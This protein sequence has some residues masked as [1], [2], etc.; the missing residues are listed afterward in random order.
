MNG[1]ASR[2]ESQSSKTFCPALLVTGLVLFATCGRADPVPVEL[3][4]VDGKW[5]L[6]R[7]GQPYLIRGAGG[8]GPL[9]RLAAA[10]ANSVRTWS[11]DNVGPILDEAHALG[12]TV[13]VGIW[14]EHERHGFD[15][16][17]R[18][19]VR[20]QVEK[21]RDAVLRYKDHPALLL[22]GVGN[23]ME[24]YESGD[25]PQIW[26]AVNDVASMV[27]E[28][29]PYHPTMT[30]TAEIG[31]GRIEM[32][33]KHT[34]AIDIHGINSYG[35]AST[36]AQ[37]M[38][39][40]GATKP[41][42]ITEFGPAGPW[43][44][45]TT[46][47]GAPHE[48]TSTQKADSYRQSYQQSILD[49]PDMALGAYAFLWGAKMEG[50]ATWFG[51]LLDDGSRLGALD[52]MEELW[53]GE[54]PADQAPT[55]E[56]IS[57]DTAT[58]IDPGTEIVAITS[59]AD[60]EGEQVSLR[61]VLRPESGDYMTGGDFRPTL[62][63]IEGVVLES[64]GGTATVR[65]PDEPGGYRLFAYASD[66]AGN[67]ATANIPL[68]VK[69]EPRARMPVSVYEDSFENMP[70]VPSGVMGN[71]KSLTLDGDW[72]ES[73]H[74]GSSAIRMHYTGR[75]GWVGV[76]WQ[77][78]ANNW[79]DE[80]GGFNL[81]GASALEF[82]VRGES[83]GEKASFGVGLLDKKTAYP[84]SVIVKTA[85][86]E[87]GSEWKKFRIPFEDGDDLSSLKVGFV[88]TLEGQRKPVTVYLD[89]IRF[90]Q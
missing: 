41:Y 25:D 58:E 12:M 89:S 73:V 57:V 56:P 78:P 82:W 48:P 72:S 62:P 20:E 14:L 23:E 52:V 65:M 22:W 40:G 10:G 7:D 11:T 80:D 9:E 8:D 66:P 31:G 61:W 88:V 79:G 76:A 39:E 43:E 51:M 54:V 64:A 83:G 35:G 75:R 1:T 81:T 29:D 3:L 86:I 84:D 13:T 50:T 27:K 28:L 60:P 37:R 90:V 6:L 33:H 34:P 46:D 21:V 36:I 71:A 70:W 30:V 74:E 77:H 87:L 32:V 68:L 15:Y 16:G 2:R 63:D 19:Q 45:P 26:A 85:M 69:G 44:T 47:W 18:G 55:I 4:E 38:R 59:V 49:N 42:V 67:A 24:G 53:S 17:D 5:Q